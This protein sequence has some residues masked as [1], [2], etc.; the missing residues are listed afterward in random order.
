MANP[1][2]FCEFGQLRRWSVFF[3]IGR[4]TA[5]HVPPGG[6]AAEDETGIGRQRQPD[7]K[8]ESLVDQID[9]SLAY[10]QIDLGVG[11]GRQEFGSYRCDRR[12]D[13]GSRVD[14]N[15][16]ARCGLQGASEFVGLFEIRKD[17]RAAIVIGLA[18]FRETDLGSCDGEAARQAGPPA[19]GPWLLTIVVDILSLR[20]AAENPPLSTWTNVVKLVNR[21]IGA[22]IIRSHWMMFPLF[23]GLSRRVRRCSY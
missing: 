13:M 9:G 3:K 8:I 16:T 5:Q 7:R 11:V 12:D 17:L 10:G 14:A 23:N 2:A 15:R 6:E 22:R 19:P 18:D 4:R 21:S 20:P 1:I